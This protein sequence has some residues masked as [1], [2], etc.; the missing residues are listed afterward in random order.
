MFDNFHSK[1]FRKSTSFIKL[2]KPS[3]MKYV[4]IWEKV[5][6]QKKP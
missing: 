5:E 4:N 6:D 2:G 1:M 3:Q